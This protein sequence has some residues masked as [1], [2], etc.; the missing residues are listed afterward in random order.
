MDLQL[1][2]QIFDLGF[3]YDIELH[4]WQQKQQAF[5][6]FGTKFNHAWYR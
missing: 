5:R 2:I 6:V 4:S 1:T 3:D